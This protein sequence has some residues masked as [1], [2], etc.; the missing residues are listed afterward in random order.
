MKFPEKYRKS[1][2]GFE[3]NLEDTFGWFIADGPCA[4]TVAM[5]ACDGSETAWDHVSVSLKDKTKTP[6]WQEMCF[7]KDLFWNNDECVV[8]FHPPKSDYVNQH[9]G[10]LHLWKYSNG[11]PTPPKICV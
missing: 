11:F 4:R 3:S 10:C 2:K 8:Q 1:F 7:V 5:L 9:Q 6:N